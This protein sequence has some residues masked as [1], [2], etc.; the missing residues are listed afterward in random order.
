MR[1]GCGVCDCSQ[2]LCCCCCCL[3]PGAALVA[4][5][6]GRHLLQL[7]WRGRRAHGPLVRSLLQSRVEHAARTVSSLVVVFTARTRPHHWTVHTTRLGE[8]AEP[9]WCLRDGG[10]DVT[11]ASPH[12]TVPID[13]A[14]L[15]GDFKTPESTRFLESGEGVRSGARLCATAACG[16]RGNTRARLVCCGVR[17]GCVVSNTRDALPAPTHPHT[18]SHTPTQPLVHTHQARPSSRWSAL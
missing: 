16:C 1:A 2:A 4:G 3:C 14:S 11:I 8:L 9:Y 12:G 10:Y 13:D 5:A 15:Q 18:H 6:H 17:G 7:L